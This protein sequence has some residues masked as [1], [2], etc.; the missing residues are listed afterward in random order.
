QSYAAQNADHREQ[1]RD[2]AKHILRLK[3]PLADPVE[4]DRDPSGSRRRPREVPEVIAPD[5]AVDSRDCLVEKLWPDRVSQ[6]LGEPGPEV[7]G[8]GPASPE[9]E[10]R[11][12]PVECERI[13]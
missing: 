5:V 11:R 7:K 10:V 8:R 3:L 13:R 9:R 1:C 2:E 6:D 4:R 12:G